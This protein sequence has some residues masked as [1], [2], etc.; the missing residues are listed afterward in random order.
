MSGNLSEALLSL[1]DG[2]MDAL[3]SV[4]GA[5][6][7]TLHAAAHRRAR[8]GVHPPLTGRA[9]LTHPPAVPPGP[10]RSLPRTAV[11]ARCPRQP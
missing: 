8:R 7:R 10:G 2:E 5:L 6:T 9:T 11:D 1:T 3:G 4:L